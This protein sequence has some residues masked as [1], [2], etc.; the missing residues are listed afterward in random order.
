MAKK[1]KE[2]INT[3]YNQLNQRKTKHV[4]KAPKPDGAFRKRI[5]THIPTCDLTCGSQLRPCEVYKAA[6]TS[7][8]GNWVN[9]KLLPDMCKQVLHKFPPVL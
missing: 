9:A 3:K 2:A 1:P 6:I 7:P 4:K 8:S 5:M